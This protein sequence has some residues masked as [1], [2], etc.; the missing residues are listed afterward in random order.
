MA[1]LGRLERLLEASGV[2]Y[3]HNVHAS[4]YTAREVAALEHLPQHRFAKAVLLKDEDGFIMAVLPADYA[5][6]L[7]ELRD[8]LGRKHARLANEKELGEQFPD[9]ELGAMPPLGNLYGLPTWMESSLVSEKQVAFNAGTH[10]D[11]VY[12]SLEDFRRL[13]APRI[14]HFARTTSH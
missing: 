9:C 7:H 2:P 1:V 13:A 14:L 4:V 10:R 11:V 5:V 3:T 6:D 8:A 12:M